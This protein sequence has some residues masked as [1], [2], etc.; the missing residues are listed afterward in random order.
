LRDWIS[1]VRK[2]LVRSALTRVATLLVTVGVTLLSA[3]PIWQWVI[4]VVV[5]RFTGQS[6]DQFAPSPWLALGIPILCILCGALVFFLQWR[7]DV[8]EAARRRA[9]SISLPPQRAWIQRIGTSQIA[10]SLRL[11]VDAGSEAGHIYRID[12]ARFVEGCRCHWA[13]EGISAPGYEGQFR[14]DGATLDVPL[15]FNEHASFEIVHTATG[16]GPTQHFDQASLENGEYEIVVRY[17]LRG[18]QLDSTLNLLV[19]QHD[20]DVSL[21]DML[22]PPP[23]LNDRVIRLAH[24]KNVLTSAE[25]RRLTALSERDR[26]LTL[27]DRERHFSA[28]PDLRLE[29]DFLLKCQAKIDAA[30]L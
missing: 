27:R 29:L 20:G 2:W 14:G 3:N 8:R 12:V 9:L 19:R 17:R 26:F 6:P 13:A 1:L 18:D 22:M 5:A 24:T 10:G 23:L 15:K 28:F 16:F 21:I 30:G 7:D 11:R 4:V 25:L